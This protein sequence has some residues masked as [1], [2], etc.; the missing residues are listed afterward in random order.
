MSTNTKSLFGRL[1]ALLVFLYITLVLIG[2]TTVF[3]VT[4]RS[5]DPTIFMMEKNHMKQAT[6]LGI[7]LFVGLLIIFTDSKFFS[8]VAYLSYTIGIFLLIITIFAGVNVKG[9][10]SWLGYGAVRFQ[11]GEVCKIF[12]SLAIAKFLSSPEINF[13]T[14]KHRIIGVALALLP[15]IIIILQK[16]TGLALVYFSFFLVMYREGLPHAI[17]ITGFSL[18]ALTVGTLLLDQYTLLI[19]ICVLAVLVGLL[20]MKA[21]KRDWNARIIFVA[22]VAICIGFSQFAVPF[23]F[24]NVMQGYQI[25]RI[26]SMFGTD[27]PEEYKKTSSEDEEVADKASTSDYNVTQSKIAIGSGGLYGKGF[28]NGT[29]TKNNFVPEQH[30]DFIFCAIGEQFGF[31]GSGIL[32]LVYVSLMMRILFI[33][34]RQ[35]SAFTRVYAYCVA[36]ILFFHFAINLSM[37]I[38]L[39]PVIGITLPL[40]SYGGSSL[41]S[42]SI[43][44]FILIR[45]D[46]DR[47]VLIR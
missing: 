11:P 12:T 22:V 37:T 7:S 13:K 16:E 24:K 34:E 18:I 47:Q 9:S 17:L 36:S 4:Y 33:A 5:T 32:I 14:L 39:A 23:V 20:M 41:L 27:V 38:G 42:F 26:Y 15:S 44:I 31:V 46:A 8:S 28:L 2:I 19:I 10:H 25:E 30:T 6:W 35:R 21:L 1:D 40:L 29:S 45:L 3:S 43:L